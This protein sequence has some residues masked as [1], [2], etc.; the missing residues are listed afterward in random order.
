MDYVLETLRD[1]GYSVTAHTYQ[2]T[3]T[4]SLAERQRLWIRDMS[5]SSACERLQHC[6]SAVRM[7]CVPSLS[8][9]LFFGKDFYDL[10]EIGLY[11]PAKETGCRINDP[12]FRNEHIDAFREAELEYPP[13]LSALPEELQAAMIP[14]EER[15]R[16]VVVYAE[17]T[18]PW[19]S[20]MKSPQFFDA[21]L[22]MRYLLGGNGHRTI[23]GEKCPT[24]SGGSRI[25]MRVQV[26]EAEKVWCLLPGYFLMRLIGFPGHP[27]DSANNRLMASFAGNAFSAFSATP[28]LMGL[29][30]TVYN[31]QFES[32]GTRAGK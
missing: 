8:P 26:S 27:T 20:K 11:W 23:F 2:A 24:I 18:E 32:R 7:M 28:V 5:G 30:S 14:L 31:E 25:W 29:F 15:V 22:S 21:N 6:H 1:L 9:E 19:P 16:E 10:R 12:L 17:L 3:D 4:G 13:K